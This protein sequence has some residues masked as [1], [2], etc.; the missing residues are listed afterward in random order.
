MYVFPNCPQLFFF[1]DDLP[2]YTQRHWRTNKGETKPIKKSLKEICTFSPRRR[3][4]MY[5][6]CCPFKS[7]NC[8]LNKR[9]EKKVKT[10]TIQ[11]VFGRIT[12]YLIYKQPTQM[13]NSTT[14]CINFNTPL[15][16]QAREVHYNWFL[17]AGIS[18]SRT[19]LDRLTN[20]NSSQ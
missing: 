9:V 12:I 13:F 2:P 16:F 17:G 5:F 15:L 4:I 7:I 11:K 8:C 3:Q 6:Q 10:V 14:L 20:G 19:A 1:I 18:P